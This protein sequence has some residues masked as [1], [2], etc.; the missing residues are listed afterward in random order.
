MIVNENERTIR[1]VGQSVVFTP[2]FWDPWWHRT[3]PLVWRYRGESRLQINASSD[4]ANNCS[5]SIFH[6][7]KNSL[8]T[9]PWSVWSCCMAVR[10]GCWPKG[11]RTNFLWL[12][13]RCSERYVRWSSTLWRRIDCATLNDQ[14]TRSP[15]TEGY[16]YSITARHTFLLPKSSLKLK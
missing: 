14:K 6:V 2:N 5:R 15:T 3:T 11:R 8:S 7:Q 9:R 12:R 1:N 10:H 13:G 16:I 4:C